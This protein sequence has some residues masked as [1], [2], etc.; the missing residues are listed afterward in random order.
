LNTISSITQ[1]CKCSSSSKCSLLQP[2]Q[3]S[4][5]SRPLQSSAAPV[6]RPSLPVTVHAIPSSESQ[7]T[8]YVTVFPSSPNKTPSES[9]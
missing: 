5:R 2:P 1:Q 6:R 7:R 4:P 8:G 3:L 9:I